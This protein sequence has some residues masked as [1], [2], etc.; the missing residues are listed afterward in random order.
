MFAHE[1]AEKSESANEIFLANAAAKPGERGDNVVEGE[2]PENNDV[3]AQ[4]LRKNEQESI[5]S[6]V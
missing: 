4:H 3:H 6:H 5:R 1:V 2:V